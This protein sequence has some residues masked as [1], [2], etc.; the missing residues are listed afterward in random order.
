[1]EYNI[2]NITSLSTIANRLYSLRLE[3]HTK[4]SKLAEYISE[5]YSKTRDLDSIRTEYYKWENGTSQPSLEMLLHLCNF[6]DCE[7]DYLLGKIEEKKH[8]HADIKEETGL[9]T[10][11]IKRI[12]TPRGNLF[13][14]TLITS[15]EFYEIDTYFSQLETVINHFNS[16]YKSLKQCE[17]K[18]QSIEKGTTEYQENDELYFSLMHSAQRWDAEQTSNIYMMGILFGKLLDEYKKKNVINTKAPGT[19]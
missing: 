6:Y 15:E 16:C 13:L 7:I 12:V 3:S 8:L 18:A 11:A 1:M 2:E 19:D 17:E 5:N 10:E 4:V 9:S 14:D